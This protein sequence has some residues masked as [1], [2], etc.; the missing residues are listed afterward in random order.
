MLFSFQAVTAVV[1]ALLVTIFGVSTTSSASA[2]VYARYSD[3][4][5]AST[6]KQVAFNISTDSSSS[7]TANLSCSSSGTSANSYYVK[8]SCLSS[9]DDNSVMT[10]AKAF[11]AASSSPYILLEVYQANTSCAT[12]SLVS[13]VAFLA[14]GKCLV[15]DNGDSSVKASVGTGGAA[16]LVTYSGASCTGVALKSNTID[17]AVTAGNSCVN[18][19]FK[20]YTSSV[21]TASSTSSASS[22]TATT[23]KSAAASVQMAPSSSSLGV[24]VMMTIALVAMAAI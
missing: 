9:S 20:L 7:C 8:Q 15:A 16:L 24:T 3:S 19:A 6:P 5:C 4:S 1:V 22:S 21:A 12:S 2:T 11:F 10:T 14:D 18:G 17:S 23:T 13:A